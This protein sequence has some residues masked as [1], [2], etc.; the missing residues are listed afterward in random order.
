[1][2]KNFRLETVFFIGLII[3][4][5]LS[6][7]PDYNFYL[8][9]KDFD[10][11]FYKVLGNPHIDFLGDKKHFLKQFFVKI[12]VLG[13]SLWYFIICILGIFLI[14]VLKK[15]NLKKVVLETLEKFFYLT[16]FSLLITG[17]LTQVFKHLFGRTRPNH[18]DEGQIFSSF[19][20]FTLDSGLHSFP[21][22]HTSTIFL[23]AFSLSFL[24]PKLKFSLYV[25]ALIIAF[26]RV[27]VGAHFFTDIIAGIIVASIGFKLFLFICENKFPT[28]KPVTTFKIKKA[29]P[30]FLVLNLIL[31][32]ILLTFGPSFDIFFSSIFYKGNGQFVFQSYYTFV[33][34]VREI[35]LPAV[36][37]YVLILPIFSKF[38]LIN[39]IFF[40]YVFSS[41]EFLFI[42]MSILLNTTVVHLFKNFWGRARPGDIIQLGGEGVFTPWYKLSDAC[43]T[44]CS[45]VSGDSAAGFSIIILYFVTQ[46]LKYIYLSIFFGLLLGI[47]RITEGAHFLSDVVFSGLMVVMFTFFLSKYFLNRQNGY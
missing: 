37:V 3:F 1:M 27:V 31:L 22:G 7:A 35:M 15:L 39:K 2:I 29:S 24:I 43:T 12:T 21:S 5:S 8:Y 9:F 28:L 44:N 38:F 47:V 42:W 26:S 6:Y 4:V 19:N 33:L 41:K 46:N 14:K 36:L 17:V 30:Q 13:S 16:F 25:F 34:L 40:N 18:L 10:K 20:F 45:F 32:S 23:I 11:G